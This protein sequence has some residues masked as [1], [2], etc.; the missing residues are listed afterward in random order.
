MN[1]SFKIALDDDTPGVDPEV[2]LRERDSRLV[3]IIEA[4]DGLI[5]SYEWRTL[6]ELVFDDVLEGID[7]KLKDEALKPEVIL[8]EVYRL[9][10]ERA[11]AKRYAS[12]EH[13]RD[14]YHRELIGIRKKLTPGGGAP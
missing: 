11:W 10:G 8:P 12:L 2:L 6:K 3:R 4:I 1:N 14:K 5:K 9:Q 13:M 7:S